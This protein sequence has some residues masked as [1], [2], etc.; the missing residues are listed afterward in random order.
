V[1]FSCH[2]ASNQGHG[3]SAQQ[4][5]AK[6]SNPDGVSDS[7]EFNVLTIPFTLLQPF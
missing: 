6:S 4:M 5:P 7:W 2:F 1:R 3:N